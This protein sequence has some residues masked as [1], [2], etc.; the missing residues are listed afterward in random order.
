MVIVAI[1]SLTRMPLTVCTKVFPLEGAPPELSVIV[2]REMD[3]GEERRMAAYTKFRDWH[4]RLELIKPEALPP[5]PSMPAHDGDFWD[6]LREDIYTLA[7]EVHMK[8]R[9]LT[10]QGPTFVPLVHLDSELVTQSTLFVSADYV[11]RGL[12]D[13][14]Q[15]RRAA[16][17]AIDAFCDIISGPALR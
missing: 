2:S 1:C 7:K 5:L 9:L 4:D 8:A 6:R 17:L 12:H 15:A 13:L 16:R 14:Q 3:L 10:A 11:V